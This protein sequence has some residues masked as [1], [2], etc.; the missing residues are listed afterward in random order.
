MPTFTVE[1]VV[2]ATVEAD[3]VEQAIEKAWESSHLLDDPVLADVY[4]E[5]GET[6]VRGRDM[7]CPRCK[8]ECLPTI[9]PICP[10]CGKTADG[11]RY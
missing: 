6:V 11:A 10:K 5:N 9:P 2:V 4:D 7:K 8:V 1:F 3:D